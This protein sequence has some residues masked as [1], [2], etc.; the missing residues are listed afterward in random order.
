MRSSSHTALLAVALLSGFPSG[1]MDFTASEPRQGRAKRKP[2]VNPAPNGFTAEQAEWNARVD[3][4]KR[5]RKIANARARR[6]AEN[7]GTMAP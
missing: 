7:A 3:D 6:V 4:N 5:A 1:A 2:Y